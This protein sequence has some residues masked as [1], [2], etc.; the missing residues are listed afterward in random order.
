MTGP[1]A[2]QLEELARLKKLLP[3]A[4]YIRQANKTSLREAA[5]AVDVPHQTLS[6]WERQDWIPRKKWEAA[7]RYL[8]LLDRLMDLN[9]ARPS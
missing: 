8:R 5:R 4:P 3:Y 6:A 7:L 9:D 1:N 2:Y